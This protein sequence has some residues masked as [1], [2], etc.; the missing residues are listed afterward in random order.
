MNA[1]CKLYAQ[2]LGAYNHSVGSYIVEALTY[3][4]GRNKMPDQDKTITEYGMNSVGALT[5]SSVC[6]LIVD[7]AQHQ[8]IATK[9]SYIADA[10]TLLSTKVVDSTKPEEALK[11]LEGG[12]LKIKDYIKSDYSINYEEMA[13]NDVTDKSFDESL[14]SMLLT[15]MRT[16][17]V[18][19]SILQAMT[20][21]E[22]LMNIVPKWS[23]D[24][25]M[26]SIEPSHAWRSDAA[27]T[28][29]F[30]DIAEFNSTYKPFDHINDPDVFASNLSSAINFAG[31]TGQAGKP[32]AIVGA[33]ST[34]PEVATW[35][36][37]R[38]NKDDSEDRYRNAITGDLTNFKWK[39]YN[40][41]SWLHV[42][43]VLPQ[44]NDDNDA[45]SDIEKQRTQTREKDTTQKQLDESEDAVNYDYQS[46]H[47]IADRI[48]KALFVHMH[49]ETATA[50]ITLLPDMRF[51]MYDNSIVFEDHIGELIDI[52][53]AD[54][55]DK[56]LAMRGMITAI[57]FV[58]DAGQSASCQYSITLSRVRPLQQEAEDI[59]CPMYVNTSAK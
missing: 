23:A 58:Y 47:D 59:E 2:P 54:E 11:Q 13:I 45:Q 4:A 6:N 44:L 52:V 46:G 49:G 1:A 39:I 17:S 22:F 16:T 19:D 43:F 21:T 36:K 10:I 55:N 5:T 27:L 32:A 8:D 15:G 48:A 41:P 37:A 25:F 26:L 30:D 14:C 3:K 9:L 35:L 38:F 42:S 31:N 56:H 18:Y 34:I 12:I 20:S 24:N 51:G 33:F 29:T 40:A 57:Q 53:P 7:A 28:I 50:Q